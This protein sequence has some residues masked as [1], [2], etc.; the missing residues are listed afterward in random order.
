[1]TPTTM[2]SQPFSHTS[3]G[4][5]IALTVRFLLELALLAGT[6]YL[7]WWLVPGWWRWPAAIVAVV[8]V[9]VVWGLFL[10]PK[11]AVPLSLIAA[12]AVEASLFLGLA[13]ALIAIPGFVFPAVVGVGVWIVDR[14]ALAVLKDRP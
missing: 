12:L 13:A 11:A 10:S 1:M 9:A 4:L 7:A 14:I 5:A 2:S 3:P 6:A 8:L